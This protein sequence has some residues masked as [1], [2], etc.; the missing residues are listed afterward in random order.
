M[1]L[2][3]ITYTSLKCYLYDLFLRPKTGSLISAKVNRKNDYKCIYYTA[4][5]N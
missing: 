5:Q 3:R 1:N 4:P 2:I